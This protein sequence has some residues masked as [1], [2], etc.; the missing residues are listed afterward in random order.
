MLGDVSARDVS[1]DRCPHCGWPAAESS[2]EPGSA[3]RTSAGTLR[4]RRCV[5]GAW[6]LVLC[7]VVVAAPNGRG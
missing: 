1:S 3:Y 5:C 7:G 4:Y 2:H 6:L